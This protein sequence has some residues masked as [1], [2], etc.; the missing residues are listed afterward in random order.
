MISFRVFPW[1]FRDKKDPR[2]NVNP[3]LPKYQVSSKLLRIN[4]YTTIF[5]N[6]GCLYVNNKINNGC[7]KFKAFWHNY[8]I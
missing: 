1:E 7:F 4:M 8:V 6:V 2:Y 3:E 5:K